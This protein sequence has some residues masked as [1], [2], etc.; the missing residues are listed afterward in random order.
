MIMDPRIKWIASTIKSGRLLHLGFIDE[1]SAVPKL[2]DYLTKNSPQPDIIG[3]DVNRKKVLGA[4]IKQSI[5]GNAKALPFKENIFQ[6]V[7]M[8]EIIEHEIYYYQ[9]LSEATRVLSVD[10][11][12][13][14]TTPSPYA[15]FR[16]LKHWILSLNPESRE[17]AR[18]FLESKEHTHFI[19]P[20]SLFNTLHRLGY[21]IVR[22]STLSLGIPYLSKKFPELYL[23][24]WPLN[25]LG[26]NL[27]LVAK[28]L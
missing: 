1:F 27:C 5:V 14:I 26:T 8:G 4:K 21:E 17:T 6:Q 9:M 23:N 24:I 16:L 13:I 11:E 10:G 20:I 22:F 19:E 3:I 2:H 25:R 12:L 28:K 7:I 18:S 15:L